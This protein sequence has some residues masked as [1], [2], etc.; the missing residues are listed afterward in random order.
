MQSW[1]IWAAFIFSIFSDKLLTSLRRIWHEVVINRTAMAAILRGPGCSLFGFE[2]MD[3]QAQCGLWAWLTLPCPLIKWRAIELK[4]NL[5]LR[6]RVWHGLIISCIPHARWTL[7][8]IHKC[9]VLK[10]KLW[11]PYICTAWENSVHQSAISQ[12]TVE[13]WKKALVVLLLFLP[14]MEEE[15]QFLSRNCFNTLQACLRNT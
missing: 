2:C 4:E 7:D 5:T 1:Y 12:I 15:N 11:G 10:G 3:A 8:H 13:D 9:R 6:L 14:V